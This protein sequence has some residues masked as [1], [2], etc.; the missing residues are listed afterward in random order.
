[1]IETFY[2]DEWRQ[3]RPWPRLLQVEQDLLISRVLVELYQCPKI[4]ETLVFRGGTA[5]NKLYFNPP[6]RYSEDIDLVQ[7]V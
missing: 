5:L 1:M 4:R 6:M 3:Q 7:I 2:L